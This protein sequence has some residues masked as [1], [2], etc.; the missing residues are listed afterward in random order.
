[1]IRTSIAG[2]NSLSNLNN[3]SQNHHHH[4]HHHHQHSLSNNNN[5]Q[6]RNVSHN[7]IE[8]EDVIFK[9]YEIGKKLGQVSTDSIYYSCN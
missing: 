9:K 8:D 7:R 1:M 6:N 5:S 3:H 2:S 4:H